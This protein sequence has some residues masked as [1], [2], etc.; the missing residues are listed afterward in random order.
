[1]LKWVDIV[2]KDDIQKI[3]EIFTEALKDNKTYIREYRIKSKKREII[4]IQERS[5]IICDD[6]GEVLHVSGVF[7]DI[8]DPKRAEEEKKI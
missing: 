7:F 1:M 3:N 6:Q 4:W 5:R 2:V 8:S